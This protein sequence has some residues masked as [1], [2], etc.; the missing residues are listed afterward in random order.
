[1]S[2]AIHPKTG[3]VFIGTS[4]G[5]VSFQ[6]DAVDAGKTFGD[7]YAYPNPVREN[8]NGVIT[9]TGLIDNT[10]VKI[11]DINGNLITQ[12][13]SNGSV[14]IWDGKNSQGKKVSSGIY[15]AICVS[16]DGTKST[17]TKIMVIN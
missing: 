17:I 4:L 10:Q 13:V 12:T 8:Y 16:D 14:A 1:L 2:I 9:I 7:V 15:L 3:E 5:L 11:T 6:S